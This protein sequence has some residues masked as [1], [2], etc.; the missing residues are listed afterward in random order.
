SQV[1]N[2][3]PFPA[4]ADADF[5]LG[6][7]PRWFTTCRVDENA[8]KIDSGVDGEL[9]RAPKPTVDL[10]EIWNAGS[11]IDLVLDHGDALPIELAEQG[12]GARAQLRIECHA[13][14]EY[15]DAA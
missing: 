2:I 4:K 12:D 14:G 5:V 6:D 13:L 8:R 9:Q 3:A 15:A 10:H 1:V 11:L 7:W